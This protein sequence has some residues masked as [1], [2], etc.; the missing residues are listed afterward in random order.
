M[1]ATRICGVLEPMSENRGGRPRRRAAHGGS[2]SVGKLVGDRHRSRRVRLWSRWRGLHIAV[3]IVTRGAHRCAS[4]V[5]ASARRDRRSSR[6]TEIAHITVTRPGLIYVVGHQRQRVRR[7][8]RGLWSLSLAA[9]LRR[10][11]LPSF[12]ILHEL[13]IESDGL[14]ARL[15]DE[16]ALRAST[17]LAHRARERQGE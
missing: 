15:A 2:Q 8:N 3:P 7:A 13:A 14:G 12:E 6:H 5:I 16:R 17:L 11:S 1:T 10:T 4:D 9:N